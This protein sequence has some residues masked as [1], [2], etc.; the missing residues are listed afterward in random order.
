[1]FKN[2]NYVTNLQNLSCHHKEVKEALLKCKKVTPDKI[3]AG[4]SN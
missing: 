4:L 3:F 2:E 1:M